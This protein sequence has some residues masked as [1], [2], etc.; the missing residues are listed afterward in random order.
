MLDTSLNRIENE[1]LRR[2]FEYPVSNNQIQNYSNFFSIVL[3]WIL[4]IL[5]SLQ[6]L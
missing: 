3:P 2:R 4:Q 6:N 5:D 1:N